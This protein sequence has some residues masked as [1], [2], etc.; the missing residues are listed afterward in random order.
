MSALVG[1][2]DNREYQMINKSNFNVLELSK[3]IFHTV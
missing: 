3:L 2:Q 1:L